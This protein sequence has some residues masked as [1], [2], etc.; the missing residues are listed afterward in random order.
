MGQRSSL[1]SGPLVMQ[2]DLDAYHALFDANPLPMFVTD[3]ET[4]RILIVNRAACEHYGW[5]REEFSTLTLRDIRPPEEMAAFEKSFAIANKTTTYSR[6]ARHRTKDGRIIEVT[7]QI[8]Q[9]MLGTLRASIAVVTD[10]TGIA[11]AE[12]RFRLLVE[13]SAD[14]IVLVNDSG[15]I[16]YVSPG[17]QRILGY[18]ASEVIGR[19]G[20]NRVHPDDVGRGRGEMPPPGETRTFVMRISHRDGS[21]RWIESTTT[22]LTHDPAVHAFV[23]NYRD[24]TERTLAEAQVRRSEANFRT[25]IERAPLA[26]FVHREGTFIYLNPASVALLGYHSADELIGRQLLDH[27][28][29][30]DREL[31]RR[32]MKH[33]VTTGG[34][35]PG[36][37]RML[38]ADGSMLIMEAEAMHLH[39][40][41]EP[42][43]VVMGR[44]VT[45]RHELFARMALA[46]RML[47]VGTLA[48]GVAH[49]INNPLAYVAANLETLASEQPNLVVSGPSRLDDRGLQ[50]LINDAREGVS[51]MSAVVRD[52]RAL[53]RPDE[54]TRGPVDVVAVLASSIKMAHNEIRHRARVVT[55]YGD[56][57]PQVD[58][59]PSRLGQVFLNLL[60]NAAHAI[61]DGDAAHNE[62]AIRVH[63][64]PD[65]KRVRIDI[66]DTGVGISP[67]VMRRIFDPF[68]TT[69]APGVGTGLGLSISHQIVRSLDG[70]IQVESA[71]GSGSTFS[72]TL[73]VATAA[74]LA[75]AS[76]QTPVTRKKGRLLLVDDEAALGRSLT[77]LLAPETQ[78][79]AVTRADDAL[80]RLT[81]GERF[82]A[83]LCD[84]MMPEIS[85]IDLYERI[86]DAAPDY[87]GR[88]I[89]MTGGAFTPKAR[90]FLAKVD[91]PHLEKP[92]SEA[93][94][95]EAL[96]RLLA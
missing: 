30:D 12:R 90:E 52:L 9:V 73:P 31:I 33:T 72:V 14:G 79:V 40:D 92:F 34:T 49:E 84:L 48:A 78:V 42:A 44:D 87:S 89:F 10:V 75:E 63:A 20:V 50:T 41:G 29:P 74:R 22:N 19:A 70:E 96:E 25:L 61:V 93:Q 91:R 47:S 32:R 77:M 11:Q 17:G 94:L 45:E 54:E 28:H 21:W 7:L 83:I 71:P 51:R 43:S 69:K 18:H 46:D 38:R 68:F 81:A 57:L 37:A 27:I 23:S 56:D 58:A 64:T 80:A 6:S 59:D 82:D 39:F 60:L 8:S 88:I 85:G 66:S 3:R 26:T 95:R 62:I 13:H 1:L 5:T 67:T 86:R 16:E 76:S 55:S 2:L 35:P 65:R 36:V 4:L 24:I 15:V 53:S